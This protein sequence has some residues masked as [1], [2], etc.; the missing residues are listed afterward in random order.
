MQ[1][2]TAFS[3]DCGMLR[4]VVNLA[5]QVVPKFFIYK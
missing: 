5:K 4:I 2:Y 3:V 1:Y